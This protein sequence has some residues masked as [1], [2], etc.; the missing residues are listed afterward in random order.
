MMMDPLL[1]ILHLTG[2]SLCISFLPLGAAGKGQKIAVAAFSDT[3]GN[4]Y[5]QSHML[6]PTPHHPASAHS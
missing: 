1:P 2:Q 5:I 4:V 3:E 6:F